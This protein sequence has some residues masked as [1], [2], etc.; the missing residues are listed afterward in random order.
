MTS[1]LSYSATF[2]G[3]RSVQ[4]LLSTLFVSLVFASLLYVYSDD[5]LRHYLSRY[6][7]WSPT[8]VWG[9]LFLGGLTFLPWL[10]L[11]LTLNLSRRGKP[12]IRISRAGVQGRIFYSQKLLLWRDIIKITHCKTTIAVVPKRQGLRAL[13][14]KIPSRF[15]LHNAMN[16]IYLPLNHLEQNSEEI[17]AMLRQ[18]APN[19][20]ILEF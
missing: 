15:G 19:P 9:Y 18:F 14:A 2:S 16:S 5:T 1:E 17:L 7:R 20:A 3:R 12:A 8:T 13:L 4:V 10:D 6:K 11:A